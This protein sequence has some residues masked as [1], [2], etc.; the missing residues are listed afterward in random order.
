L[1]ANYQDVSILFIP[2]TEMMIGPKPVEHQKHWVNDICKELDLD[3]VLLVSSEASW[4]Q[5]GKDKRTQE[6]I[7]EDMEVAVG[8]AILYPLRSYNLAM[9]ELNRKEPSLPKSIPVASYTT[10]VTVPVTL[11]VPEAEQTFETIEKNV[12]APFFGTYQALSALII[13]RINT[14]L[15]QLQKSHE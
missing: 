14:D 10:K 11:T 7:P 3:A 13:D 2:A 4:T 6:V 8:A 15:R 5:G 9:K 1:P 12:L